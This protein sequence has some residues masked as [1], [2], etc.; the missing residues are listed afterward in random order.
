MARIEG[1]TATQTLRNTV[2]LSRP[3]HDHTPTTMSTSARLTCNRCCRTFKAEGHLLSHKRQVPY[4]RDDE[5]DLD[6]TLDNS[7]LVPNDFDVQE[8]DP[9][10]EN[11]GELTEEMIAMLLDAFDSAVPAAQPHRPLPPPL[12]SAPRPSLLPP[13]VVS[14]DADIDYFPGAGKVIRKEDSVYKWWL[15]KH[16]HETNLYHPFK[17]K[18]DWEIGRW[19]KQ[20]GS[21]ATALDRPLKMN[22]YV[23]N[24][25]LNVTL[26][27]HP[28]RLHTDSIYH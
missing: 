18:L 21:G 16:G 4:C 8:D 11:E 12:P 25:S 28:L 17:T 13:K 5:L 19:A 26:R 23:Q 10:W 14:P 3:Q 24:F 22:P 6:H 1:L 9:P 20:E 2:P 15:A 27:L 7:N